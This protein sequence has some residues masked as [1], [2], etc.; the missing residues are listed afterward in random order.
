MNRLT[1]LLV[2]CA[3]LVSGIHPAFAERSEPREVAPIVQDGV[4]YSAPHGAMAVVVATEVK[5]GKELWRVQVYKTRMIPELESDVQDVFITSLAVK[6]GTLLIAN[7]R[8]EKFALDL[9]TRKVTRQ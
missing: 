8:G 1:L 6:D 9:Q 3:A 7:E 5:T 4:R 2:F